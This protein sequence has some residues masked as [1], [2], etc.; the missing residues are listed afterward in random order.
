MTKKVV[1]VEMDDSLRLVKEIFDNVS[2]HHLL[3][4][5]GGKLYGVISDRDLLKNL[6][7]NIG[8][9]AETSRDLAALNKKA[10]QIMSRKP[11]V[12][13]EDGSVYEAIDIFVEQSISCIPIINTKDQ[14]IGIISWRDI[15]K[16][17]ASSRQKN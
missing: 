12:L 10:H 4:V 6:S 14:P 16:A 8:T 13:R 3:V 15:L 17:S 1:T 5:D 11:I 9:V 2:F 7:P